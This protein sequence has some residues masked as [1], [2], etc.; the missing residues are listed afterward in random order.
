MK[1]LTVLVAA[2]A[3]AGAAITFAQAPE[4]AQQPAQQTAP[5]PGISQPIQPTGNSYY[6]GYG[7][8]PGGGHASTAAEGAARGMADVVRSQ[9]EASL[10]KSAAAINYTVARSNQIQN[11]AAWTSTYF[12]MREENRAR[13]AAERRPRASMADLVRY[14]QAGK[15][16]QLS[17]SEL[18][19][20]TGAVNWPAFLKGNEYAKSRAELE[21]VYARRSSSGAVSAADYVKIREVTN[22]ML[23]QLK[24]QIKD[25]P[26]AQYTASKRFLQSLAY[27]IN[28]PLG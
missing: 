10:N 4:P 23:A 1:R 9:G 20:V 16:Q 11:R 17:P 6:G 27:E 15:P 14:A 28:R 5:K 3:V 13:R 19:V 22:A 7:G 8:Y 24:G 12:D 2:A 21:A 25:I 26:P 18:N